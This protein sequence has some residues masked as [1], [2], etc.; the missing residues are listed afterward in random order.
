MERV[1]LEEIE[2]TT[3]DDVAGRT[4]LSPALD[5]TN[6]AINRYRIWPGEGLP[7]GLHA[8]RDQE[9]VFVVLHGTATFETYPPL[10]DDALAGDRPGGDELRVEAGEVVRF[11]PGEFQS[12]RNDGEGE[13]DLLALG[14]PRETGDVRI[15]FACPDC[16]G[17]T[18]QLD[19]GGESLSLACPACDAERVPAPCPDCERDELRTTL[20][21][22]RYPV[23]VCRHCDATFDGPP[24]RD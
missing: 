22:D 16:G 3:Q 14:A 19:V 20:D 12:G 17:S 18:L 10:D 6:V 23:V 15:P 11:A 1:S 21:D 4:K 13:L 9:E 24:L 7:G 5:A 8:H 2:T